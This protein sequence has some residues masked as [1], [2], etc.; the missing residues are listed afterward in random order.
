MACWAEMDSARLSRARDLIF[1]VHTL[2]RVCVI[3]DGEKER[4][5]II[6]A[7]EHASIYACVYLHKMFEG[8]L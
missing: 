8:L 7:R 2:E 6:K 4:E 1:G 5:M 3:D